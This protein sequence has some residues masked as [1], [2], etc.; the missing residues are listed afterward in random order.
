MAWRMVMAHAASQSRR[1]YRI[2]EFTR[3]EEAFQ[4]SGNSWQQSWTKGRIEKSGQ[5][6]NEL[7]GFH[8]RYGD[9]LYCTWSACWW[10]AFM[11]RNP[12]VKG[13]IRGEYDEYGVIGT[14]HKRG[15]T[16]VSLSPRSVWVKPLMFEIVH[17][18]LHTRT[19]T[20][21]FR[22]S[23]QFLQPSKKEKIIPES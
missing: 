3:C 15:K 4:S 17:H 11:E 22:P 5:G 8:M 14:Q 21:E 2:C 10:V 23:R 1:D 13:S 18:V 9:A 19:Y 7:K 6:V 12:P 16:R 20:E